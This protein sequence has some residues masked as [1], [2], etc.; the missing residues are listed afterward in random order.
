MWEDVDFKELTNS[1]FDYLTT[2]AENCVVIFTAPWC[3]PCKMLKPMIPAIA[4]EY[5]IT[6]FWLDIQKNMDIASQFK[7]QAV[8]T[9]ATFKGGVLVESF[10][11]NDTRKISE[12]VSRLRL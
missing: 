3:S 6:P 8:P 5:N 10:A 1:D 7:I 4:K 9:I 11:T 12:M 2:S